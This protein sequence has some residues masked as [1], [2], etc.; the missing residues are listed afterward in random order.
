MDMCAINIPSSA[1]LVVCLR[2]LRFLT[3][4]VLPERASRWLNAKR[5]AFLRPTCAITIPG[6]VTKQRLDTVRTRT[7]VRLVVRTIYM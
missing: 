6:L 7:L 4:Q 2:Y 3:F 1:F 5:S